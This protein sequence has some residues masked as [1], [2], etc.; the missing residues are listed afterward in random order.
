MNNKQMSK[1]LKSILTKIQAGESNEL[2]ESYISGIIHTFD[3]IEDNSDTYMEQLRQQILTPRDQYPYWQ[4]PNYGD[5][6]I[7]YKVC[8]NIT[9][10]SDTSKYK[11]VEPNVKTSE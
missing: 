1:I 7:T 8:N 6:G 2:I 10:E 5:N 3:I 11:L 4:N 9:G